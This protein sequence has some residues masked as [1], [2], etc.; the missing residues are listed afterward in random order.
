MSSNR[1]RPHEVVVSGTLQPPVSPEQLSLAVRYAAL[2]GALGKFGRHFGTSQRLVIPAPT[3]HLAD[4]VE[5]WRCHHQDPTTAQDAKLQFHDDIPGAK[6]VAVYDAARNLV[7]VY[8]FDATDWVAV[9]D[10]GVGGTVEVLARRRI[11]FMVGVPVRVHD[12]LH[13]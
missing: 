6:K 4:E 1:S 9:L 12:G 3:L 8:P 5:W 2:R 10:P 13:Q 7:A 11:P